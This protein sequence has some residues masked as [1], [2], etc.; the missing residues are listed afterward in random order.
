[1]EKPGFD[2]GM[3]Y[4]RAFAIFS[5][6]A[7]HMWITP[8]VEG[9]EE[10]SRFLDMLRGVLF[11][12]STL[13]FIFISGYLFHFL[14]QKG[15]ATLI[16]YR[17]KINNVII[18]YLFLSVFFTIYA[19]IWNAYTGEIPRFARLASGFGEFFEAVLYGNVVP[20]YW[21]IPFIATVFVI[22]P[23]L[24]R[25]DKR[26][27]GLLTLFTAWVPLLIPRTELTDF[28]HNYAF[29]FP[30]YLIGIFFSMHREAVLAFIAER[31]R[32]FAAFAAVFTLVLAADRYSPLLPNDEAAY[33]LQKL[34]IGACVIHGFERIRHVRV[35]VLD[36][37]A[38]YSFAL[39]FLHDFILFTFQASLFRV[40][41][42]VLPDSLFLVSL[43][44]FGSE[45]ALCLLLGM[46]VKKMF[47]ARSRYLIGA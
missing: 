45:V 12:S 14:S 10:L 13:Y 17:K 33:Y 9:H 5:V 35:A 6:M 16:Y 46:S 43:L 21:Y 37:I 29:F 32:L 20:T 39:Y 18:P 30:L 4:F 40:F 31:L 27:F 19:F 23:P 36:L 8:P 44:T 25:L 38:R 3:H 26:R 42:Y 34:C 41:G 7:V 11:H 28:F 1:M 22:S 47:R 2:F 15:F 24:L